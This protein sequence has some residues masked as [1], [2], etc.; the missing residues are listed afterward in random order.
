MLGA[1]FYCRNID[2]SKLKPGDRVP[3]T[4][5]IEGKINNLFI[6]YKG[7]ETVTTRDKHSYNCNKF[8]VMLV[9]GTIFKGGEDMFVWVSD[10]PNRVPILVEAKILFGSVKGFLKSAENLRYPLSAEFVKTKKSKVK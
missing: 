2:F 3:V 5:P 8:S 4:V 6:R 9:E 7:K 10:D 1:I